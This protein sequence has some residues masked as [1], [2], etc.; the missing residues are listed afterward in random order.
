MYRKANSGEL[1]ASVLNF[2]PTAAAQSSSALCC[3]SSGLYII[4]RPRLLS[5]S[6]V[7][8]GRFVGG[9][10]GVVRKQ[11]PVPC[12]LFSGNKCHPSGFLSLLFGNGIKL[13]PSHLEKWLNRDSRARAPCFCMFQPYS[14]LTL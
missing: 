8:P 5:A 3:G 6:T 2:P 7:S 10:V 1:K 14:F 4:S 13:S 9:G 11:Q 12:T